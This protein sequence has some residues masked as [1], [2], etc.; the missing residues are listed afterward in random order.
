L[1]P[2]GALRLQAEL[3][4]R[5]LGPAVRGAPAP[6]T[7]HLPVL[8]SLWHQ[9]CILSPRCL[10]AGLTIAARPRGTGTPS[11]R[12]PLAR[13]NG[14]DLPELTG[15]HV[16]AVDPHLD[17]DRAIGGARDRRAEVDVR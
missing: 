16:A 2:A 10:R 13:R 15:Q 9:H 11:L 1:Q 6:A 17:P 12:R 14:V 7:M 8:N 5:H 4:E 3:A